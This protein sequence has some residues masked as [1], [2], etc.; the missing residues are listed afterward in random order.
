MGLNPL[1]LCVL[2]EFWLVNST[3]KIPVDDNLVWL[4]MF[5]GFDYCDAK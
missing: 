3:I 2:S 1:P 4:D 5:Y